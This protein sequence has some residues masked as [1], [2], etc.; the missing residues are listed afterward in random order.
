ML[1]SRVE[2]H[3]RPPV[4]IPGG[5][6]VE[7]L[8]KKPCCIIAIPDLCRQETP[9]GEAS[10]SHDAALAVDCAG[11]SPP[12][13]TTPSSDSPSYRWGPTIGSPWAPLRRLVSL[14]SRLPSAW[15]ARLRVSGSG[16]SAET[17]EPPSPLCC[18]K[19]PPSCSASSPAY[20]SGPLPRTGRSALPPGGARGGASP[21]AAGTSWRRSSARSARP[22]SPKKASSASGSK[23]STRT[24]TISSCG[25]ATATN[26]VPC[27]W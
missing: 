8:C 5:S 4:A 27:S 20:L 25:S 23:Y 21:A 2:G 13:G 22:S 6:R 24:R 17:A 11:G 16:S 10:H 14:S 15:S 3:Q 9:Q 26:P 1:D 7:T 18:S 12:S 19:L